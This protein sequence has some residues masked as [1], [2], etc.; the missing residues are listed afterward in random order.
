MFLTRAGQWNAIRVNS[1]VFRDPPVQD[2]AT[3]RYPHDLR[4]SS[5][6]PDAG[7]HAHGSTGDAN[8]VGS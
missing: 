7:C 2:K 4:R 6:L 1:A 5:N 8:G 3:V